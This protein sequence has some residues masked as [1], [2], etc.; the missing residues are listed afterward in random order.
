MIQISYKV[1]MVF[2]LLG[3]CFTLSAQNRCDELR[4]ELEQLE[5][6][7]REIKSELKKD[8]CGQPSAEC[9][10]E[11]SAFKQ[12]EVKSG[13]AELK[14]RTLRIHFKIKH[15]DTS[16]PNTR[17]SFRVSNTKVFDQNGKTYTSNLIKAGGESKDRGIIYLEMVYDTWYD[18]YAEFFIGNESVSSVKLFQLD[19]AKTFDFQNIDIKSK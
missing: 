10:E 3:A 13:C 19:G 17:T 14:G 8:D 11:K 1:F 16:K 7:V 4:Q 2:L 12:F 15:T 9:K 18:C 5:K 6:R